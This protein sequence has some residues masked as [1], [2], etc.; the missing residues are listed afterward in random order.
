MEL[1]DNTD[2]LS[3]FSMTPYYYKTGRTEQERLEALDSLTVQ[4]DFEILTYR[5]K[6]N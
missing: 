5:K 2:I 3:L 4:A 1:P 6:G